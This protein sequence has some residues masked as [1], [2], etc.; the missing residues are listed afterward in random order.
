MRLS[1]GLG[2]LGLGWQSSDPSAC[3]GV[4]AVGLGLVLMLCFFFES[5]RD[6]KTL[7]EQLSLNY[8][9][10]PKLKTLTAKASTL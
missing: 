2:S 9:G 4:S 1:W 6:P 10:R 3:L 7:L 8:A 5:A